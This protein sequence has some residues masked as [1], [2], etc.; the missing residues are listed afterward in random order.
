[1][2]SLAGVTAWLHPAWL[3]DVCAKEGAAEA[4]SQTV[5][6]VAVAGWALVRTRQGA[7]AGWVAL[8]CAVVLAEELDWGAQLGFTALVELMG[9][10]NLHNGLGGA[11]YLIFAVPWVVLYAAALRGVESP[12]WVPP[13]LDG[14]A[15]GLVVLTAGISL[16]VPSAWERA[17]DEL[18][19]LMLYVLLAVGGTRSARL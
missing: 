13:R 6:L 11:S 3:L 12:R 19:E 17:L 1:M 4:S 7:A 15:F 18:S 14:V 2:A 8:G 16:F 9:V 5:L 10:P